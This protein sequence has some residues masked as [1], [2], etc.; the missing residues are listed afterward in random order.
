[1]IT[2]TDVL[3]ELANCIDEEMAAEMQAQ[4]LEHLKM[5]RNYSGLVNTTRGTI[6]VIADHF[7]SDLPAGLSERLIERLGTR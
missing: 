5:C 3:E 1:M 7:I 6:T 2:C 4:I